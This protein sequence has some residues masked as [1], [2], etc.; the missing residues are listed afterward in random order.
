LPRLI[1]V[2]YFG[3][4]MKKLLSKL[5]IVLLLFAFVFGCS[6]SSTESQNSYEVRSGI[7][8]L[9]SHQGFDFST[10]RLIKIRSDSSVFIED[11]DLIDL[12]FSSF[13]NPSEPGEPPNP[14]EFKVIGSPIGFIYVEFT[15]GLYFLVEPDPNMPAIKKIAE[16]ELNNIAEISPSGFEPSVD[17]LNTNFVYAIKNQ[18]SKYSIFTISQIDTLSDTTNVLIDWRY[19]PDGSNKFK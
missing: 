19:Q 18:D 15:G 2:F 16:D 4:N 6:K 10:E 5:F 17:K 3:G 8:K 13:Q 12:Y 1:A 11:V 9:N 14:F 7:I